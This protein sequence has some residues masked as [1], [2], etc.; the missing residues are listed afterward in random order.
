L[1]DA[2]LE[3]LLILRQGTVIEVNQPLLNLT[4]YQREDLIGKNAADLLPPT[5]NNGI[6]FDD[7]SFYMAPREVRIA[8]G[9]GQSLTAKMQV[10]EIAWQGQAAQVVA[11]QDI[12]DYK[13]LEHKTIEL[14]SE[15]VKLKDAL[16]ARDHLGGLVGQSQAMQNVY[17][18]LIDFANS[19]ETVIIYGETGTGK[20]LAAQTVFNLSSRHNEKFIPVNCGAIPDNLFESEFFGYRKGAFTGTVCDTSGHFEKACGGVLFLDEISELSLPGQ[21][22]LLRVLNDK[23]YTPVGASIPC[24]ADVRIIAASAQNLAE[25]VQNGLMRADFFY[26]ICVLCLEMPALRYR[27]EDIPLLIS[28]FMDMNTSS[29]TPPPMIT[30]SIGSL[31]R[32]CDWPGNVRELFNVLRRYLSTGEIESAG[33]ILQKRT[34]QIDSM[35]V[36]ES[37]QLFSESVSAFEKRLI[38]KALKETGDNKKAAA[39]LL[40]MPLA[41]MHRKTKKYGLNYRKRR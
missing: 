12:T 18:R 9:E 17:K 27:K 29:D 35:A 37:G 20:E 4:G 28:H 30:P 41:T 24:T 25:M 3:G 38:R 8:A 32:N 34:P 16:A 10:R 22:K 6:R 1:A 31:L 39:E 7:G 11:L 15:N 23:T 40:R 21:A 19:D 26:R 2:T 33:A 5:Q 14:E 36:P 13:A